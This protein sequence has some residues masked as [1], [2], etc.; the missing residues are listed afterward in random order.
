MNKA[1]SPARP[2]F[3]TFYC[4][5]FLAEHT[6]PMNISLHVTGTLLGSA[7]IPWALFMGLPWLIVLYPVVHALPGLLG[8]RFLER[9]AAVGDIRV[10]RKDY[11]PLWFIVGNHILTYQVAARGMRRLLRR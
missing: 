9:N 4:T 8:H 3:A 7:L 5:V 1:Q 2:S 10:M 6:H 11:S